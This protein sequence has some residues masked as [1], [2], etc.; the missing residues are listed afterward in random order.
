MLV[1]R[2]RAPCRWILQ[3][4]CHPAMVTLGQRGLMWPQPMCNGR[5]Q[6]APDQRLPRWSDGTTAPWPKGHNLPP[7]HRRHLSELLWVQNRQ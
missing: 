4:H 2:L 6:Q 1:S 3:P 5:P 7:C